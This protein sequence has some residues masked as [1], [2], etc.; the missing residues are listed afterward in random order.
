MDHHD[1]ACYSLALVFTHDLRPAATRNAQRSVPNADPQRKGPMWISSSVDGV[2]A[3]S[4]GG[5]KQPKEPYV[6]KGHATSN[7]TY[8]S[9]AWQGLGANLWGWDNGQN[10]F[11]SVPKKHPGDK[12]HALIIWW[13]NGQNAFSSVPEKHPGDK[14][15]SLIIWWDNGQ[16]AFSSVPK[17]HP[18]DKHHS[19]IIWWDNGQNAFSSVPKKHPG[20]KHH[21]LIIWWDN[22]QNAFCSVRKKQPG[23]KHHTLIIWWDNGQN[24]QNAFPSVPKKHPVHKHHS[25]IIWWDNLFQKASK[26]WVANRGRRVAQRRRQPVSAHDISYQKDWVPC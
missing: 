3:F 24:I 7:G 21:S 26:I 12:H 4:P 6:L 20:D 13:D 14:H 23:D 22:G 1:H 10:A 19:L 25:L 15:P 5:K 8:C 2:D 16:N 18:G 9:T 11:S 17:K